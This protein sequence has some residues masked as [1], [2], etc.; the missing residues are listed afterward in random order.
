MYYCSPG[1]NG[2]APGCLKE[3]IGDCKESAV[4]IPG[5]GITNSIY[6]ILWEHEYIE[7][8][9]PGWRLGSQSLHFEEGKYYDII[10]YHTEKSHGYIWFD[11]SNIKL[12]FD[13]VKDYWRLAREE[14]GKEN[15]KSSTG[16]D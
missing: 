6:A 8:K 5:N 13:G 1:V 10:H 2:A 4:I 11:L 15:G 3:M 14:R 7:E 16:S 12:G 9:H